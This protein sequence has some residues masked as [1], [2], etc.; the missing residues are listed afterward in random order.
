MIRQRRALGEGTKDGRPEDAEAW[1][2]ATEDLCCDRP[3]NNGSIRRIASCGLYAH[4]VGNEVSRDL[5]SQ[6]RQY[7]PVTQALYRAL[8]V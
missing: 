7:G 3:L 8:D 5:H 6:C 2:L 1:R 4:K